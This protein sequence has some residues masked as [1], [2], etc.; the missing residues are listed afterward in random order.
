[1]QRCGITYPRP[2]G[3]LV[4]QPGFH[5][6][7]PEPRAWVPVYLMYLQMMFCWRH[8]LAQG[9]ALVLAVCYCPFAPFPSLSLLRFI[10]FYLEWQGQELPS[11]H[12]KP[13][14][15]GC[16]KKASPRFFITILLESRHSCSHLPKKHNSP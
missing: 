3:Y 10:C 14:L 9:Q 12:E 4:L 16:K 6:R 15:N 11:I 1:M 5:D 13:I 8:H 7:Q 2:N